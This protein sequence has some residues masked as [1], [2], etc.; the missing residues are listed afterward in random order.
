MCSVYVTR[1]RSRVSR[2]GKILQI[3]VTERDGI[4]DRSGVFM[5]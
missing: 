3:Y 5:Y 4:T 2:P 1:G